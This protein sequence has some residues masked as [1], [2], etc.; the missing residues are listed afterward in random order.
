MVCVSDWCVKRLMADR[1]LNTSTHDCH[2]FCFRIGT[3]SSGYGF[4]RAPRVRVGRL[5]IFTAVRS[6]V[7]CGS[8]VSRSF[9]ARCTAR[10]SSGFI[11]GIVFSGRFSAMGARS[12]Y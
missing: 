10:A 5:N 3:T 2:L 6:S 4:R 8:L 1:S 7:F 9:F 12:G 11:G